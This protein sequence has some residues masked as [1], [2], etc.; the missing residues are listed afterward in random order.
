MANKNKVWNRNIHSS[1]MWHESSL[2]GNLNASRAWNLKAFH[3]NDL[4]FNNVVNWIN[5]NKTKW[6]NNPPLWYTDDWKNKLPKKIRET[7]YSKKEN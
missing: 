1:R 5:K 2:E 4:G 6:E 3:L 7:C